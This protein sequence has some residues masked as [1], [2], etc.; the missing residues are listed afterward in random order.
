MTD[1]GLDLKWDLVQSLI[2]WPS[3]YVVRKKRK[4]SHV[5]FKYPQI[6]K[7]E[8]RLGNIA[9]WHCLLKLYITLVWTKLESRFPGCCCYGPS[10]LSLS[11]PSF[12]REWGFGERGWWVCLGGEQ[13]VE[14]KILQM[15]FRGS[16]ARVFLVSS[17]PRLL[18]S[19]WVKAIF[20]RH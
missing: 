20:W 12:I 2:S 9:Q 5:S 17:V 4:V 1:Q 7:R 3:Y 15:V 14:L 18:E 13:N 16:Q 6:K 11:F 19:E 8:V 10:Q